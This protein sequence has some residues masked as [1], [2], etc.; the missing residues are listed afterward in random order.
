MQKNTIIT[1]GV[2][3]TA[4]FNAINNGIYLLSCCEN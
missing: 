3:S 4:N 2:I 1:W